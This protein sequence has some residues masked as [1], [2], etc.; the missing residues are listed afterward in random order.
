MTNR[1]SPYLVLG[2]PYG[3]SKN[4]AAKA[5]A[6]ATRRLRQ[7]VDPPFDLED[8]NWALHAIE[9]RVKEPLSSIDDYRMPADP[10]VYEVPTGD[11]ILNPP[12]QEYRRR[13]LETDAAVIDDLHA[14]ILLELAA[15]LAAEFRAA[16]LPTLHFFPE[17]GSR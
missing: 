13:T 6:R 12:V 14:A 4:E 7:Q 15:E 8:V 3:A 9:Q 5:F 16:P 17:K 2:V 10:S 1:R 11:G